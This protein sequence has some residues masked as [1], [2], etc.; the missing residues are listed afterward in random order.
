MKVKIAQIQ[1]HVYEEKSKNLEELERNL[2]RIKDENIDLVTL[3]EM[4]NCPYQT[5]CFP[6]YAEM[7]QGET[8]QRLSAL[9]KKYK[10]Y[11]SAG[12]VPEKDKEGHVYNTLMSLSGRATRLQNT[13]KCICLI[14]P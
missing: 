3:G 10:I 8:W 9:A 12:S 7:E 4:F 5:P 14:S 6:V 11:L 13:A 2:K 1:A